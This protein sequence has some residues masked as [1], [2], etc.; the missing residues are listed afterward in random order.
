[1]VWSSV[2]RR[3]ESQKIRYEVLPYVA[4][5]GLD[6]GCGPVKVW[7]HLIGVDNM[8]D[9][10]IFGNV[11]KPDI[12]VRNAAR[13]G[14]FSDGSA[15]SIFSS[16]LL[17]HIEDWHGALREWWRLLKNDGF[18]CLYLPHAELYP[19]IGEPGANPDHK[20]DFL[21]EHIVD[22]CRL[23]FGD[24]AL[25]KFD[26]RNDTDEY[27][28]LIVI[29]KKAKGHGQTEPWN[30]P[31]PALKAGIVRLGGNGDALWSA[32][33]ASHLK[34][35]GYEVTAYVAANGEEVLRY[36]P[37]FA[38]IVVLPI[39]ILND[40]E[41]IEYWAN[42]AVKFDKWINLI[43]SVEGRLLPHQSAQEFYLPQGVRHKL[44]NH[45][46]LDLVHAYAELPEGTKSAAK[47]Y[48]NADEVKWAKETRDRLKGKLVVIS[49][50][51]SGLFKAWPHTQK[52]MELLAD[53][54][55]YSIMVGDLKH[56]PDL[57]LVERNGIEYGHVVG[58]EFPL[59][60]A[61]T[62]C[63]FADA[64]V[65]TESVFANVVANEAM[66]KVIMLSHSSHENLTRD[67]SNTA[68]LS[69]PVSCHPCHRIHNAAAVM[70]ARDTTSGL[71]ACMA[72]YSA[73]YVSDLIM[74]SLGIEK[75]LAA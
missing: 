63:L 47:F 68:A 39:G 20:H 16:H 48:A 26:T 4:R 43:G 38:E 50:T 71:S 7:P 46:Y 36:D 12:V 73:E 59:R 28:F 22:F 66:P 6:L 19:R 41:M 54:G 13:L 35:Q 24:W 62:L 70:C 33:V 34:S 5:G 58:Q 15:E 29:Q 49:P 1:M 45:N 69:A 14:I 72:S 53:E 2:N 52:L 17:E 64:F 3:H 42:E 37:N 9:T 40:E 21:P 27:S 51:G 55:I 10:E 67:W 57:D 18:L 75:R 61:M 60:L 11:F 65:G 32:S 25:V 23:A 31:R 30:A 74:K 44:M 56:L 8:S